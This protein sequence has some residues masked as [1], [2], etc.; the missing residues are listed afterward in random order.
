MPAG[1]SLIIPHNN[2]IK[3][4]FVRTYQKSTKFK[5]FLLEQLKNLIET[6]KRIFVSEY[7]FRRAAPLLFGL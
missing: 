5:N 6:N 4:N 2:T 7:I 3:K 1:I